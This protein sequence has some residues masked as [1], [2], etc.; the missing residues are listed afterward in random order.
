MSEKFFHEVFQIIADVYTAYKR[1]T[2]KMHSVN[3]DISSDIV[4]EDFN[5]LKNWQKICLQKYH[6]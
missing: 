4:D 3:R 5:E 6:D 2:D 1:K